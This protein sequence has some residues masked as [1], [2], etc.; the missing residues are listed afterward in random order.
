FL[1]PPESTAVGTY[2][3]YIR[4]TAD[5]V[6]PAEL[7]ATI[8]VLTTT[9]GTLDFTVTDGAGIPVDGATVMA[10]NQSGRTVYGPD[11][12]RIV[13]DTESQVTDANGQI[14]FTELYPAEYGYVIDADGY[15]I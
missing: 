13:Y 9:T 4:V 12:Q 3:R 11:G 14:T 7:A 5:D 6:S 8:H 10:T 2:Q 1:N 15:Y